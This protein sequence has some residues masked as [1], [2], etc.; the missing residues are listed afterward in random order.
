M[1]V[2]LEKKMR[3]LDNFVIFLIFLSL[4]LIVTS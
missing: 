3:I 2:G 1:F 4:P